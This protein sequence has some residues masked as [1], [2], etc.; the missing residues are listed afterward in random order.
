MTEFM[1]LLNL[2]VKIKKVL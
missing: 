1:N 2:C